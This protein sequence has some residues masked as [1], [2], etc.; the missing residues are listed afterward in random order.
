LITFQRRFF[1][2]LEEHQQV[3]DSQFSF[4]L[5][6]EKY[7]IYASSRNKRITSLVLRNHNLQKMSFY[8][9]FSQGKFVLL[10]VSLFSDVSKIQK[11]IK[12]WNC[13]SQYLSTWRDL[14][15][16]LSWF[17]SIS[18]WQLSLDPQERKLQMLKSFN[19]KSMR[20]F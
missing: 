1:K 16:R 18:F 19:W 20:F 11:K 2:L 4:S 3:C 10:E 12:F 7:A 15:R 5:L 14:C 17:L 9:L 8:S 13:F 6:S